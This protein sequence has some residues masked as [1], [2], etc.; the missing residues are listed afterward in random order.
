MKHKSIIGIISTIFLVGICLS[1]I[2]FFDRILINPEIV[3][4]ITFIA[5]TVLCIMFFHAADNCERNEKNKNLTMVI[6][7]DLYI[8]RNEKVNKL[9]RLLIKVSMLF[10]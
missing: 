3:F 10:M 4:F 9:N 2:S 7:K 1:I 8:C 5:L 6:N